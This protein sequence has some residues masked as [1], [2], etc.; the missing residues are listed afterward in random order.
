[1]WTPSRGCLVKQSHVAWGVPR[2][3]AGTWEVGALFRGWG[4]SQQ[5]CPSELPKGVPL[6]LSLQTFPTLLL[7]MS[8][9]PLRVQHLPLGDQRLEE[10]V[11]L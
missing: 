5:P 4:G 9:A 6:T 11:L 3:L 10:G 2:A 1:M 7:L 8:S